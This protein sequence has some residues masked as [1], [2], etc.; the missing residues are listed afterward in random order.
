M[1]DHRTGRALLAAL[2]GAILG[3]VSVAFHFGIEGWSYLMTG[4]SDY[5]QHL[6]EPHGFLKW[7]KWFVIL[8]PAI[9][10]LIYGPLI[11]K[12]APSARGHGIPEVM[13]AVKR[14]GGKIPGQVAVVKVVASALTI[15]GGGSA[16]REGPIVQVGAS[17]GS[18]LARR[19]GLTT[20]QVILFAGCGSAAGIA[21]TFNAP[22]AGAVFAIELILIKFSAETF[23]MVVISAVT[24]SLVSHIFLPDVPIV[25]IPSDLRIFTSVD[26]VWVLII[27]ILASLAGL[28]F[29]K[30]LYKVEDLINFV[31]RGPE[32]ARPALGGLLIGV[33]LYFFPHMYGSGYPIQLEALQ[34]KYTIGFL[35]LLA[36]G[37]AIYTSTTI[38]VGGSGGVFAPTLFIGAVVGSAYG[39][40]IEPLSTS[41]AA[42]YG[43]IG[44]GAAFA[45]AARAP[46]TSVLIIV[47]MTG[48]YSL[49]MPMML[50]V[51]VATAVSRFFSNS[52]IYTEKLIRRGDILDDPV[53]KTLVG[54][55]PARDLMTSI[56]AKIS[57]NTTIEDANQKLLDTSMTRLPVVDSDD[58]FLGCFTSLNWAE[59]YAKG[60]PLDTP[61]SAVDLDQVAVTADMR[62]SQ[63]L[64]SLV[65]NN[66]SAVVVVEDK[67]AVGWIS[68]KDLVALIYQQQSSALEKLRPEPSF[69]SRFRA[70]YPKLFQPQTQPKKTK[71]RNGDNKNGKKT[72]R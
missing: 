3:L 40:L 45:G 4:Y 48:Q 6:G 26:F 39:Q 11:T 21:A 68:Q 51:A 24:S 44:M 47:E 58:N 53:E 63:V 8:V 66:A 10:G 52:T 60:V 43:V 29:S 57:V 12:F 49:I 56:P 28:A 71:K 50:A 5:T 7:G 18:A 41:P 62:P 9:S 69:A 22:L 33:M 35:L 15:G 20:S 25:A 1:R 42:V 72:E 67:K 38:G 2:L 31:Y 14:N 37:R 46:L 36:L 30:I 64:A 17:L 65:D 13:L 23:G 55:V 32:W 59:L 19:T 16:G 61:L 27:G 70:R 54:R 34:G